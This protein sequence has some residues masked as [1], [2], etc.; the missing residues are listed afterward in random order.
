[1]LVIHEINGFNSNEPQGI[2]L[3]RVVCPFK[4]CLII[5]IRDFSAQLWLP[6]SS[7]FPGLLT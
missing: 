2:S 1:M 4:R 5:R 6:L 7:L 3:V